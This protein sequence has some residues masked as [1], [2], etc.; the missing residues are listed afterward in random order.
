MKWRCEDAGGRAAPELLAALAKWPA[1]ARLVETPTV[2]VRL[3]R[4]PRG[5]EAVLKRY[6]FPRLLRRLEAAF[7]HSWLTARPKAARELRALRRLR[8]LG[9]PAVEPLGWGV[10]RDRLGFVRDSFL[11]TRHWPQP[12][13]ARLL[14]D[15]GPPPP[16]AWHALGVSVAAMHA[17]GVRHGGLAPRNVLVGQPTDGR[18]QVRWL[19]PARAQFRD[20]RLPRGEAERDLD[21]LRPTLEAAPPEARAAFEEGY[22]SP[23][24]WS[25]A[26]SAGSTSSASPT[27]P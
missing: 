17:R 26:A 19:D 23:S 1:L 9:V 24:F 21:A 3:L 2:E 14:Q 6:R 12:D 27:R 10:V 13:L 22:C 20:R 16:A 15:H 5:G 7:R 8:E 4:D 25:P 18:W 11:L